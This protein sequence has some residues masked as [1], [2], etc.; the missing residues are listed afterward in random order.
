MQ[1]LRR[2]LVGDLRAQRGAFFAVWITVVLG[3]TFYGAT[4]PAGISLIDSFL[5]TYDQLHYA[6]FHAHFDYES[7]DDVLTAL[8]DV[9]GIAAVEGRLVTDAG[10]TLP[11]GTPLTLRLISLP[12]RPDAPPHAP[13]V[14]NVLVMDGDSIQAAGEILLLES[15]ADYHGYQP[16]DALTVTI[17]DTAY[18]FTVSGLVFTPEYLVAGRD[19]LNPFPMPNS[20]GVAYVTQHR[21]ETA[22]DQ[23]G[24]IN[25][26][27]L[28]LAPDADPDVVRGALEAALAP[29][30]PDFLNSQVQM[31]SGGVVD[32]NIRG[33]MSVAAFFSAMFLLIGELVMAILL[34]RLMDAETR[35]IGTMRAL[36]LGRL[37]ILRH[38]L[39]FPLLIAISGA[40]VGSTLGY[41]NSF[42]V[43]SFFIQTLTGGSLPEFVNAPQWPFI[44]FGVGITVVLA[45]IAS[46]VPT[47]R[48][49]NIAPGLALRPATPKGL[50]ARAR[51]S[52]PGM[53]L[54]VQQ[55]VRNMLRAPLRTLNTLLGVMLGCIVIFSASGTADA[56]IR[57]VQVQYT[58]GPRYD[59]QV[60]WGVP[61]LAEPRADQVR[62]VAGV[63]AVTMALAGPA[64]AAANGHTLDTYAISMDN[65]REVIRYVTVD[66]DPAFSREDAVWIGH[67]L[68]RVLDL[69]TGDML[70]IA[71]LGQQQTAEVAG[72]VDLSIGS[73][74]LVPAALMR[75]WT[76]LGVSAVNMALVEVAA[77]ADLIA[78]RA[79]LE[80][81][82]GV[83]SVEDA[84][85]NAQDLA[86]YMSFWIEFSY[87]FQGFG[88]LLTL[89]VIFNTVAINLHERQEELAIMRTMGASLGE[90]ARTITWET[91]SLTGLGMV[92]SLPLGWA[93]L[94][95]MLGNYDLDFFGMLNYIAPGSY[96]LAVVGIV[97]VVLLAEWLGLRALKH[98]DLGR[99]SKSLA[100]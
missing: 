24:Q 89:V 64:A 93:A 31:P 65:R 77:D 61:N 84:Q 68:A 9:P 75:T 88:Y 80:A 86:T 36:G 38:Y 10:L 22:L 56:C 55:A 42:L 53:P 50:G 66:G 99:L 30:E 79:A 35:R 71:A 2:K 82:P 58:D 81:L 95:W 39:T 29:Y 21:L 43:S 76:P 54:A 73:P 90:I 62:A 57:S 94:D 47:W 33:D 46:A 98:V 87:V 28:T 91:L 70:D 78:V 37:Q 15:F 7:S 26:V 51:V 27:A 48:A 4:Y 14:N 34:A 1:T 44:L 40:V 18:P 83:I 32:A 6:D 25:D 16:G 74:V 12:K 92:L 23:S 20:F 13:D 49:S 45:L 5:A 19:G 67:N 17:N 11:G 85:V 59:L 100:S 63:E 97:A 8:A 60:V 72:V 3:L 96:V 41:L 69:H 52:L